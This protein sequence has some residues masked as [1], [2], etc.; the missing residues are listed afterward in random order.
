[1]VSESY[2]IFNHSQDHGRMNDVIN[3]IKDNYRDKVELEDLANLAKMTKNSF[4]R[5][6]KQKTGKTPIQ[7][8]SELRVSHA[9]RLLRST[10]MVLK[11]ICYDSG[12]NNFVN[13]HKIFKGI[14]NTSPKQYKKNSNT[15]L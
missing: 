14:T 6:F 10:D 4:C 12:F 5:Y 8:V 2:G 9:C 11:E 13:F 15:N 1:M 3:Y 7:F